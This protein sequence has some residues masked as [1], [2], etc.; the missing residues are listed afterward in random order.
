MAVRQQPEELS[1][2][3]WDEVA[4]LLFK[5]RG[6]T[7]GLWS[8]GV[9]FNFAA[10]NA[11]QSPADVLPTAFAAVRGLQ[12]RRVEKPGPLVF[13]ASEI[14]GERARLALALPAERPAPLR[15]AKGKASGKSAAKAPAKRR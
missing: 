6:I 7:T 3:E 11:G 8:F 14:T 12:I 10:L 9:R 4:A 1:E 13:D 15:A 5:A 2:F